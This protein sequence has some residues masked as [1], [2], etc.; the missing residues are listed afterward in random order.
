MKV[1]R[2]KRNKQKQKS[3]R[4]PDKYGMEK[5]KIG[6]YKKWKTRDSEMTKAKVRKKNMQNLLDKKYIHVYIDE[7]AGGLE[8]YVDLIAH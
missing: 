3:K 1:K 5:N 7:K 8:D 4:H 6:K 2:E